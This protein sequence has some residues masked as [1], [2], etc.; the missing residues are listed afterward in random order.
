MWKR[1]KTHQKVCWVLFICYLLMLTHFMFFS[2]GFSRSEYTEY[3]YNITLFK[4]IKRFYTYREL[5]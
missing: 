4:E 5:L 3:H 2:D 1:T